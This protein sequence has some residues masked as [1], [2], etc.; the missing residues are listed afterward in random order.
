MATLLIIDDSESARA[1][2][3]ALAL[4][5]G[6][7]SQV[8]E[9]R[10]GTHGLRLML[11]EAPGVVVCDLELPG[12]DAEQL[13][14][15]KA[16][17]ANLVNVPILV[18]TSSDDAVR[19]TRLLER[20]AA[21]V[22]AKPYHGP[23]IAARMRLHLK[24]RQLQEELREKNETLGRLSTIDAVTGLRNRR[25]VTDLLNIEFQKSKRYGEPL[26]VVMMDLDHF[27][28]VND[29][30]GHLAGDAVLEGVAKHLQAYLRTTDVAGR[31]GG[32]EFLAVLHHSAP[33]GAAVM[34][35]RVRL[36][37]EHAVFEGPETRPVEVTVSMGIA[38]FVPEM[39]ESEEII[40]AADRA[41][42]AAKEAG[43]NCVM[44]ARPDGG[45]DRVRPQ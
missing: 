29:T 33:D 15:A 10:D 42:Y 31:Y 30:L 21:D 44:I 3:R 36:A 24:I 25:Y 39:I 5:S 6:S 34:A 27:K 23:E 13:I 38:S 2:L 43:R 41:L 22:I 9:A 11:S 7:F 14:R 32:E 16:G 37:I 18:V 12:F 8:I 26:S 40:A 28:Q 19:R 4:E 20:G 17:H 1:E 45:F 35:E